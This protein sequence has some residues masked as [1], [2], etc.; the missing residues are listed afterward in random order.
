MIRLAL[1]GAGRLAQA[2]APFWRITIK[3][4]WTDRLRG[5][6]THP[7]AERKRPQKT[8]ARHSL[9]RHPP[10][11]RLNPGWRRKGTLTLW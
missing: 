6:R 10:L 1:V 2:Q 11:K 3:P 4:S 5:H 8:S 7:L 9:F